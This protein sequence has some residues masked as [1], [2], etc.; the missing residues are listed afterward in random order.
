MTPLGKPVVPEV[1]CMLHTS[2]G[3]TCLAMARTTSA[4]TIS[5]RAMASSKV[6]QPL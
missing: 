6:R 1:Y 2:S 3:F 4:G 5:E